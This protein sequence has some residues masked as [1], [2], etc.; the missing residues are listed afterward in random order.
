ML[1]IT[2]LLYKF[3]SV[4]YILFLFPFFCRVYGART[5]PPYTTLF[6]NFHIFEDFCIFLCFF[7]IIFVFAKIQFKSS[8]INSYF[9]LRTA[10]FSVWVVYGALHSSLTLYMVPGTYL[11]SILINCNLWLR[12]IK[13]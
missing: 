7:M 6:F 12:I 8:N 11:R 5:Y 2:Y 9:N 1:N 10:I 4:F 13:F 3:C